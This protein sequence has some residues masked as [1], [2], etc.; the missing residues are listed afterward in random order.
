MALPSGSDCN[1]VAWAAGFFDGEGCTY[2]SRDGRARSLSIA[3]NEAGPL[4]RFQRAVGA[5]SVT[6]PY[7]AVRQ[8][9]PHLIWS[10]A[11]TADIR[12]VLMKLWPYLSQPKRDDA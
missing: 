3:Q 8:T 2:C 5:G 4:H 9:R 10:T 12:M 11:K 6:G 1:E 7:N